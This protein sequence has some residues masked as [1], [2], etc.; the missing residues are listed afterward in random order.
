MATSEMVLWLVAWAAGFYVLFMLWYFGERL[1]DL[2]DELRA[3]GK[4]ISAIREE[5]RKL[6]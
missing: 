6:H 3:I 2:V 4:A 1:A 5:L